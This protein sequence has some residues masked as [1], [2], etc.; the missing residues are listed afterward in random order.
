MLLLLGR[1]K[2]GHCTF[3]GWWLGDCNAQPSKSDSDGDGEV[4]AWSAGALGELLAIGS[5]LNRLLPVAHL[6]N[7]L[8]RAIEM[9]ADGKQAAIYRGAGMIQGSFFSLINSTS[10]RSL[11]LV[12]QLCQNLCLPPSRLLLEEISIEDPAWTMAREII[13]KKEESITERKT[14]NNKKNK[15]RL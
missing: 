12:M 13:R 7:N 3:C 14:I 15:Q 6:Q 9:L 8:K 11:P 10:P 4:Q 5:T 1:S 2:P